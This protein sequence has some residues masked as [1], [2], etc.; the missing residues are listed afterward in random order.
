[1]QD[2]PNS[3]LLLGRGLSTPTTIPGVAGKVIQYG[4]ADLY[5]KQREAIFAPERISLIEASVK[6]GKSLPL[7]ALV[8]TPRGP[9]LMGDI[10]VGQEV[11]TPDGGRS[12][13][14][15]VFP[16]GREKVFEVTFRDGSVAEASADHLWEIGSTW[17]GLREG[18][19][20]DTAELA[21]YGHKRLVGTFVPTIGVTAFES[22]P[23]S[24]DPYVLGALIGDGG[25]SNP[26]AVLLSTEDGEL[27]QMVS[28]RLDARYEVAPTEK[29]TYRLR[30]R[31]PYQ[32]VA[33]A[34]R[35]I[36]QLRGLGLMGK[37]SHEKFV[38]DDY[39]YNSSDVRWDVLRGIFDTDGTV[40]K[41]GQ[42]ALEQTSPQLAEDVKELVES[43]GGYVRTTTRRGSYVAANGER[44]WCR[45]VY[46][47]TVS[48][49]DS[50]SFFNLSRKA[51]RCRP[52]KRSVRRYF[53]SV[54]P[55]RVTETQC[56]KIAEPRGLFLTDHLIPTHN[57]VG[58]LAWLLERAMEGRE[59]MNFW[60]GAPVFI[61]AEIGFRRM[62][63]KLPKGF[64]KANQSKLTLTLANGARIWFKSCERWDDLYGEDVY[65]VV[66]DEASRMREE[67]WTAIR[68][69]L[70]AT[71]GP[72]RMIGNVRGRNN[73]F[74]RLC[75]L[76]EEGAPG[77]AYHRIT[78][79]D[80]VA[81]GVLALEEIESS[82]TD[83]ER[84]GK[85]GLWNQ[86]YNAIATAEDENPFGLA[87]IAACVIPGE[88]M[89]V[90]ASG[91]S[92]WRNPD[93]LWPRAAG[94]DLAGRGAQNINPAAESHERDF[95]AI[96][97][98]DREGT[99]T[100][101]ERFRSSHQDTL[102]RLLAT[103]GP[104]MALVDS[105]GAGD[106][107]VEAMQRRVGPRVEGFIFGQRSRQDLL[108]GL[109][110]AIGEGR[111][112]FPD[113]PLRDELDS[114]E[115]AYTGTG[116][117]FQVPPGQHDD[118]AMALALAVKKL[119]WRTGQLRAPIG[120]PKVGGSLWTNEGAS[121]R[122]EP[123]LL[124]ERQD[125]PPQEETKVPMPIL[126]RGRGYSG[127]SKWSGADR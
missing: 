77:M 93:E 19:I 70:T 115:Y 8:Y 23:I 96:V 59:G 32:T 33:E 88:T 44:V 46:R 15:G 108:E 52:K 119:P 31:V 60:W 125:P 61:Q 98:L 54:R 42:P 100:H 13:V 69:T 111:L 101:V 21:S 127:G 50:A 6:A 24:L 124:G 65:A 49:P 62:A 43:L 102:E 3:C 12:R 112:R 105:T 29:C 40:N 64:Y 39:R 120:V 90:Q 83:Y 14:L 1:M 58:C 27:L 2:D 5:P 99:A 114:F 25:L 11:C 57:T 18:A 107:Q 72:V 71:Q 121:V 113:G 20:V 48:H 80:A 123:S 89:R 17:N 117:R 16:Q 26:E 9:L 30:L 84:L 79:E 76:A 66:L 41:H 82:R 51:E 75:R 126:V 38:P 86:L 55:S 45:T 56:I 28:A 73:W 22:R 110:L 92:V 10:R 34:D 109:A 36:P 67:A 81:A 122:Q 37:G 106:Q 7:D 4:G 68:S 63:Q 94:V 85:I 87:A 103:I 118:L 104:T 47:Q 97:K 74:Y 53:Q 78:W 35:L 95:S 91:D 116:V